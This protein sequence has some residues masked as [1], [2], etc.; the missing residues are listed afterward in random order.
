MERTSKPKKINSR[1][2]G[3]RGERAVAKILRDFGFKDA[4]RGVQF[5][6]LQ[7]DA[8]VVDAIP[9]IHLEIKNVEKLNIDAA[10]EQSERDAHAEFVKTGKPVVPVV[11]H[12]KNRTDWKITMHFKDFLDMFG[13]QLKRGDGDE[14]NSSS[15]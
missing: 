2:K 11:V 4:K 12:K 13:E 5:S 9:G 1:A 15:L 6:G 14:G 10:M 7:G 8:D 3:A